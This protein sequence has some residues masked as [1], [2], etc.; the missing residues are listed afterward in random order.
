MQQKKDIQVKEQGPFRIDKLN[1]AQLYTLTVRNVSVAFGIGSKAKGIR[2]ITPPIISSTLYPGEISSTAI[3]I[4]FGES[5]PEQGQFE[6][7]ELTFSG[8]EKNITRKLAMADERSLTF[9]GLIPGKTYN[10]AVYT[11][12]KGVRSRPVT[13]NI[14][15][16][17]NK[18]SKLFP[19]MGRDYVVLYWEVEN[20][21]DND[22]RYRLSYSGTANTGFQ[23][24]STVELQNK[25]KHK[26]T[27]M[28]ADTYYTF[29]IIVIMGEGDA[30]AESSSESTTVGF[31][32]RARSLP[33]VVRYGKRELAVDFENDHNTFSDTNGVI[34]NYAVIVTEDT[35]LESD[36]YE[37]M[38]WYQVKDERVWPA[39]RASQSNY[40][41][42]RSRTVKSTTFI[43]GE[44]DC[45]K[46]RL[47][48]PY[49]NGPLRPNVD[50]YVKIRA[51]SVSNV[52]METEWVSINGLVEEGAEPGGQSCTVYEN[53]SQTA[54]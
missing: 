31:G 44:N 15:T 32:P 48:E 37:L 20:L 22:C 2:Q 6:H 21:A 19:V 53:S 11:V 9:T 47:D 30:E 50:Y 27:N 46:R 51:Y 8:Q 42:F 25:T 35:T 41:P 45:A 43:V 39:Y 3:N 36:D 4:N 34:S 33:T 12:Y 49:C 17:P 54:S 29:T 16:Y 52:A 18:V 13:A 1:P 14:T 40:N 28:N 24:T 26:F 10:F 5:D 23:S 38:A 7:Y